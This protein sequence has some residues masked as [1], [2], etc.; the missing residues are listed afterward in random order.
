MPF[1]ILIVNSLVIMWVIC[2][3]HYDWLSIVNPGIIGLKQLWNDDDDGAINNLLFMN[4]KVGFARQARKTD[5]CDHY[6]WL[7]KFSFLKSLLPIEVFSCYY[8]TYKPCC[9]CKQRKLQCNTN[10]VG[11]VGFKRPA[12]IVWA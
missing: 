1:L 10:L 7:W 12:P 5:P 11:S 3:Y 2:D 6:A 4:N 9:R 8:K